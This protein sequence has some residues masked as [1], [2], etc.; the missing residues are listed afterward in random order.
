MVDAG[1]SGWRNF[2]DF[3]AKIID[4]AK[5]RVL[6]L[7]N[8][9]GGGMGV[10]S[11][12]DAADMDPEAAAKMARAHP[13]VIVGFKSAHYKGPGW[14]SVDGA[15]KAANQTRLPVMVDFGY[16]TRERNINA[17]FM[18][19]LRPGDIYTHCYSGH[20][21][22]VVDGKLNPAME[23]GRKRGI[24]FDVGHGGGSFYWNV[25]LPAV[26][27]KFW[28]DSISTDL[29]TGSQNAGMKD[30]TN[31]MSKILS[32]G[33]PLEEVIRMSTWNP[34]NEIHRP[35]LGNLDPGAEADVTVLRLDKGSFGFLDSAGARWTGTRFLVAEMTVRKGV[36]EWDLN[37]RAAVDWKSFPY[38]KRPDPQ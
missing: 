31:V 17:L 30:M 26:E 23:A 29:H 18:D 25:A 37:G 38:R 15:V 6:A 35:A 12:N 13:D 27:Q 1:T 19:K 20:R 5:T 21:Q 33:A 32:M 28:P 14:P 2:P 22:E 9:V 10:T 8:I 4:R 7:L 34:A 36:V 11:E 16:A 3:K 24:L